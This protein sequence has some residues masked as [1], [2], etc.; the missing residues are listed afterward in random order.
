M[1]WSIQFDYDKDIDPVFVHK[2]FYFLVSRG[3]K[4]NSKHEGRYNIIPNGHAKVIGNAENE[5]KDST[6]KLAEI[7]N[8]YIMYGLRNANLD[9][10]LDYTGEVDFYFGV[11]I[12]PVR[13]NTNKSFISI[14]S[15][16][17]EVADSKSFFIFMD[18]CKEIFL[19]FNF[20][21]GAFRSQYQPVIPSDEREF[22][23]EKP[24]VVNFYSK[25]M[26]DVIGREKLLST[27]AVKVEELEN[28]G[29]MLIICTEAIGCPDEL[30]MVWKHLGY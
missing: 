29:V 9:V 18:L 14:D 11:F 26:V 27:P 16:D 13:D 4:Y 20:S 15:N 25:S 2:L 30:R 24:N 22:L 21:Y 1:E 19:K 23:K 17:Y 6:E 5:I 8:A 10:L 28:G 12:N 3:V 7:I